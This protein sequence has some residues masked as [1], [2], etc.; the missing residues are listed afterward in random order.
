MYAE[1]FLGA[2]QHI[3]LGNGK[4]RPQK[5]GRTK[6][7]YHMKH[8]RLGRLRGNLVLAREGRNGEP[9][10][11]SNAPPLGWSG[12][13]SQVSHYLTFLVSTGF[14]FTYAL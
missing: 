1:F 13:K 4:Q 14:D 11:L 3:K 5:R 12:L 8:K 9:Q 10:W 7:T 2:I 6:N